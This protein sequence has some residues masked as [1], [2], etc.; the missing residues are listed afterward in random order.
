MATALTDKRFFT[1]GEHPMHQF[2]DAL[3]NGAVG[4]QIRLD[5]TGQMME[6]RV[7]RAVEKA[8]EWFRDQRVDIAAI[9]RELIAANERDAARARRMV[10]RLAEMEQARLRML[11]AKRDAA[12]MINAGLEDYE[13]PGAIG[14]VSERPLVRQRPTGD[15]QARRPVP[16]VGTAPAHDTSSHGVRAIQRGRHAGDPG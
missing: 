3:Q 7:E 11:A 12:L 15:G 13:L 5:R 8:L 14:E 2:L 16:G 4:W 9:T 1:P 10:Q 6:Q